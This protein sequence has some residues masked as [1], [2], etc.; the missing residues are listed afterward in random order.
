M[1]LKKTIKHS[2]G[3]YTIEG[4]YTKEEIDLIILAGLNT[5]YQAGALPMIKLDETDLAK[6]AP[7][8]DET[9]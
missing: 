2:D 1:H 5:L 3:S 8:K 4:E 6:Y 7:Y 9:Q